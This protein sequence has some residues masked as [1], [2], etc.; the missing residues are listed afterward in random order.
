MN[1]FYAQCGHKINN[2][3]DKFCYKCGKPIIRIWEDEEIHN[4]NIGDIISNWEKTK[5]PWELNIKSSNTYDTYSKLE[6]PEGFE[7]EIYSEA[8]YELDK[9]QDENPSAT[10]EE[11]DVFIKNLSNKIIVKYFQ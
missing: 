7:K 3:T 1:N 4:K 5:K 11:I 8:Y 9:W 2:I 10:K 6:F